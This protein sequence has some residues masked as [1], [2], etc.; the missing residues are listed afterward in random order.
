MYR[1][2]RDRAKKGFQKAERYQLLSERALKKTFGNCI[3]NFHYQVFV[4]ENSMIFIQI[5]MYSILF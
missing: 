2:I 3:L 1:L 5:T 4:N